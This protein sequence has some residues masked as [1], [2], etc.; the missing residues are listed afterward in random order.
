MATFEAQLANWAQRTLAGVL[1]DATQRVAKH[2]GANTPPESG[3]AHEI[4]QAA[5]NKVPGVS[6]SYPER[7]GDPEAAKRGDAESDLKGVNQ[8][9][10]IHAN[11]GFIRTLEYGGRISP[12][13]PGGTKQGN[14]KYPGPFM[15]PRN[16]SPPMGFLAFKGKDGKVRF[17][18][19]VT[20]SANLFITKAVAQAASEIRK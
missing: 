15:G 17:V 8:Q 19:S 16:S 11:A 6:V 14:D 3:N 20:R 9:V 4:W 1:V 18:R 7:S 12:I 2:V 5:F 10:K 13:A